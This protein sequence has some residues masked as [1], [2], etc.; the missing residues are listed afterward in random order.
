MRRSLSLP[1]RARPRFKFFRDTLSELK[2]VV[3][4]SRREASHLTTIVIIVSIA[5]GL[6]LGAVDLFFS[7]IV[8]TFLLGG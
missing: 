8:S 5:V 4:P 1:A 7:R 2:K 6:I 3:W